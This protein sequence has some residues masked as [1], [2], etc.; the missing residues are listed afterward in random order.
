M[1]EDNPTSAVAFRD[2]Q[3]DIL[4]QAVSAWGKESQWNM[5][6]GECGEFV[7]LCAR[8]EQGRMKKEEAIDE[9]AD[10]LIMMQQ[11]ALMLGPELVQQRVDAKM[12]RLQGILRGDVDHPHKLRERGK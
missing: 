9:C 2:E 11:V 6:F 8:R 10:V 3:Y 5:A 4:K 7:A 12:D 1:E